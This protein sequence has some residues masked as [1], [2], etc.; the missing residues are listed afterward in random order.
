VV[1]HTAFRRAFQHIRN[2]RCA[3][4]Q[5]NIASTSVL[6]A[7]QAQFQQC[8]IGLRC[9]RFVNISAMTR[10]FLING[11]QS[12]NG[13]DMWRSARDVK[14]RC[15]IGCVQLCVYNE[16]AHI[17]VYMR[18]LGC[19]ERDPACAQTPTPV[20]SGLPS[21]STFLICSSTLDVHWLSGMI[22][23]NLNT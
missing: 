10:A 5:T 20:S 14:S 7:G 8:A 3:R 4:E 22:L 6:A 15:Y 13:V 2:R 23:S 19:V 16:R 17:F 12:Q 18:A 1:S 11:L 9:H 21:T